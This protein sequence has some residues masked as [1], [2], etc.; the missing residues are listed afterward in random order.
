MSKLFTSCG[1]SGATLANRV[2]IGRPMS[3]GPPNMM[4]AMPSL[5]VLLI[6]AHP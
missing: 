2:V 3:A 4:A 1:L 5:A 6:L